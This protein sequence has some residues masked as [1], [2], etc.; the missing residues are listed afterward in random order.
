MALPPE[1]LNPLLRDI[2]ED[3]PATFFLVQHIGEGNSSLAEVL[4]R[5]GSLKIV[6]P[7]DKEAIQRSHF[8]VAPAD[9]HLLM[10]DGHVR[11]SKGPRENRHRPSIDALFRS[12]AR[13]YRS[14][15]IAIVLTGAL[16]DGAAGA[17]A[18]KARGGLVI[19]QDPKEAFVSGM[20]QAVLRAVSV[21]YCLPRDK[22]PPTLR[23]LV[24]QEAPATPNGLTAEP[25]KTF[26][27]KDQEGEL[28]PFTCPECDGPL[29]SYKDGKVSR[30]HCLIGHAFSSESLTEAHREALERALLTAM[31]KLRERANIHEALAQKADGPENN[32]QPRYAEAAQSANRDAALLQEILERI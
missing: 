20:P 24:T 18:V 23:K 11:L 1:A 7:M 16:D 2:P 4:S 32:L 22:I 30:L 26:S 10:E 29:F 21:D 9:R 8:Y 17:V 19:V 31:R 27:P 3:F 25:A 12:A 5:C 13:N 6:T 15:V 28:V 14:R